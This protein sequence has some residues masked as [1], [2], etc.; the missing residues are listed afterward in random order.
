MS[1]GCAPNGL[2]R[3]G[4]L[5]SGPVNSTDMPH[6]PPRTDTPPVKPP[7]VLRPLDF[8]DPLRWLAAGWRDFIRCPGIGLFYGG[9]SMV[10]GGRW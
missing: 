4:G 9:C 3:C 8:G 7:I 2:R 10:M 6:G 1:S 5:D